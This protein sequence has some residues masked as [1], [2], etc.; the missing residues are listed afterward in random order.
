MMLQ[1]TFL[2]DLEKTVALLA[3]EDVSKCP[4]AELLDESQRVK[5]ASEVNAAI[6]TS[7]SHETG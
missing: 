6:L 1:P 3:F 5:T 7:Q 2:E 4:V